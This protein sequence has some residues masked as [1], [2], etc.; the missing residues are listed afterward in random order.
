MAAGGACFAASTTLSGRIAVAKSGSR[1]RA[2]NRTAAAAR[3]PH[4]NI[5]GLALL[6]LGV[7]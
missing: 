6:A 3:R 7:W 5:S 4:G 1:K 2:R